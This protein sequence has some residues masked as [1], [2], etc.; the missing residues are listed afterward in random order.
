MIGVLAGGSLSSE[1]RTA[2]QIGLGMALQSTLLLGLGLL[3][4]SLLR[5]RGA[6]LQSLLYQVTLFGT[7]SGATFSFV[8]GP[9]L[10]LPWSVSLPPV[11]PRPARQTALDGWPASPD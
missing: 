11:A 7:L 5:H 1:C 4:G 6:S 2:L 8:L 9:H 10:Q 3:A